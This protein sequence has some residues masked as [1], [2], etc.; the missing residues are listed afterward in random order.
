MYGRFA[1]ASE[2]SKPWIDVFSS[3]IELHK[4][5]ENY[6]KQKTALNRDYLTVCKGPIP[7]PCGAYHV[8]IRKGLPQPA[9]SIPLFHGNVSN[10]SSKLDTF[11][12]TECS[13]N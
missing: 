4:K 1:E 9:E 11:W 7:E 13:L 12:R 8:K 6:E 5:I 3:I 2:R 10:L